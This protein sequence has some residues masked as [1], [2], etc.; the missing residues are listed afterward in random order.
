MVGGGEGSRGFVC[1]FC[2]FVEL[3]IYNKKSRERGLDSER[4]V[5]L[6]CSVLSL[7]FKK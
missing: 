3:R 5:L 7:L 4:A 6:C 1:W 2:V